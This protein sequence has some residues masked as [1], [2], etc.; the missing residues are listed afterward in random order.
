MRDQ[1]LSLSD[2]RSSANDQ[3]SLTK[4]PKQEGS[5]H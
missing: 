2:M 5:E 4:I 1:G 3:S